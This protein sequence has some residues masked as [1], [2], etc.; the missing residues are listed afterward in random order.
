M[1]VNP[2]DAVFG[3][4][5]V[6]QSEDIV[7]PLHTLTERCADAGIDLDVAE[8]AGV[9]WCEDSR[10]MPG[11]HGPLQAAAHSG[12]TAVRDDG[13][14]WFFVWPPNPDIQPAKNGLDII[15]G[16][17][18]EHLTLFADPVSALQAVGQVSASA[19]AWI[20][21]PKGWRGPRRALLPDIARRS[22]TRLDLRPAQL[23]DP[24]FF[25]EWK[26]LAE[27]ARAA[28]L[29]VTVEGKPTREAFAD[30]PQ[31]AKQKAQRLVAAAT[32]MAENATLSDPVKKARATSGVFV[33]RAGLDTDVFARAVIACFDGHVASGPGGL[34]TWSDGVWS[35]GFALHSGAGPVE[36]V[37]AALLRNDFRPGHE[38]TAM[39]YLA[40]L[41][42]LP[43]LTGNP[44]LD[45]WE[46]TLNFSNG[47]LDLGM[48]TLRPHTPES[49]STW[50]LQGRYAPQAQC[51]RFR[52]VLAEI[53]PADMLVEED[54]VAPWQEDLG[55]LL[56]P[57]NPFH[58]AF[59]LRGG[60]RNGKGVWMTVVERMVGAAACSSLTLDDIIDTSKSRFRLL[61]LVGSAV[62]LAGEVDPHMVKS[63][64]T[65][66]SL[67]GGD[68]VTLERKHHDA[69][70]YH[71][72]ATMVFSANKD[73][74]SSD[75]SVA[76]FD[77][78]Q[79]R[80]FPNYIPEHRRIADLGILLAD[81]EMDGIL[82][83]A[84]DGLVR[85]RE[86]GRFEPTESSKFQKE[87]F[88]RSS[89]QM[90]RFAD[91]R[92]VFERGETV[93][94]SVLRS[95]YTMWCESEGV[96]PLTAHTMYEAIRAVGEERGV[97]VED[98]VVKGVRGLRGVGTQP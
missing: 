71:P 28:G 73:F 55:Y 23:D 15:T 29:T 19:I 3:E 74:A 61:G 37:I 83:A 90:M 2:L 60:G 43:T 7:T 32:P 63:T 72:W 34:W 77:R 25:R 51:P 18:H 17:D 68:P 58:T 78:W 62:N 35:P 12:F 31:T 65:F 47:L 30:P 64:A 41:D 33:S 67:T 95:A 66:K 88:R 76:Y 57:G 8:A 54:G 94:R 87:T 13:E 11:L 27:K 50:Q 81:A 26:S 16:H 6:A 20:P 56:L 52:Q 82:A 49:L 89:D 75:R 84:V 93:D 21:G 91:E 45:Q 44:R 36:K 42:E 9:E 40:R 70:L 53:L 69:F 86:R 38:A 79:V 97:D 46:H 92:L 4:D 1:S 85:L 59:L 96:K 14:R 80:A 22:G 5:G 24:G 39:K 98:R 48:M 10:D